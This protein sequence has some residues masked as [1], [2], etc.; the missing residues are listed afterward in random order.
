MSLFSALISSA[1]NSSTPTRSPST[2]ISH[3]LIFLYPA[4]CSG[5]FLLILNTL[6]SNI[7]IMSSVFIQKIEYFLLTF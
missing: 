5:S 3:F 4:G 7:R 6:Y 2:L 1:V